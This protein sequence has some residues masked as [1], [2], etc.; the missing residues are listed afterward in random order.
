MLHLA[1][2]LLIQISDARNHKHKIQQVATAICI[3]WSYEIHTERKP[4]IF[5]WF[6]SV[7]R[8][9]CVLQFQHQDFV[10]HPWPAVKYY[11][12]Q[13][14]LVYGVSQH[15]VYPV[16]GILVSLPLRGMLQP[17]ILQPVHVPSKQGSCWGG[18]NMDC[19][20]LHS[21]PCLKYLI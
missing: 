21:H 8:K 1:G 4:H 6:H 19:T 18:N 20:K 11:H 9:P 17:Q 14:S 13:L 10:A 2:Q 3:K 15:V 12:I 16:T 5:I 7:W